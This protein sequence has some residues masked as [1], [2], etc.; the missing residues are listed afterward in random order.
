MCRSI[1]RLHEA[2]RIIILC[3]LILFATAHACAQSPSGGTLPGPQPSP[4]PQASPTQTL[5]RRFFAH[6][7]RDQRAIWT[8][9]FAIRHSDAKW[10]APLGLS[11]VALF[12][13]DRRSASELAEN[14]DHRS[15]LRISGDI[16]RGGSIYATGGTAAAFYLI[17]RATDNKRAR[18]TGLLAAEALIDSGI[19]V[20]TL[21][22][23]TQ[24]PRPRV[25]DA[26][27]EFFDR[28]NSFPSGHAISAWSLAAVVAGEYRHQRLVQV[29]AYGL[30]AAVSV[31]RYT[32]RNHF[33]SDVLVGSAIGYG[34]GHYVY[35]KNHDPALDT[36]NGGTN[37]GKTRSR[38]L[39]LVSPR[40]S[41]AA[42]AYGVKLAWEL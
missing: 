41:R 16:S 3:S 35:K 1:K 31:S 6:I 12:A 25:D 33:L 4:T 2:W 17:G 14:G 40:Y 13:T 8:S 34:I 15:R 20:Q 9:P 30:A 11:T 21:K 10:L 23:V 5:E 39:P 42:H 28:G 29:S 22:A 18:E 19:V 32:G 36:T 27:G 7:L 38:L 24:R 37:S 26:S